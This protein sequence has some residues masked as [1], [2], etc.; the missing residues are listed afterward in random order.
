MLQAKA[1]MSTIGKVQRKGQ[2]TIPTEVRRQAGL[3]QGDI[4][5]FAFRRGKIVITPKPPIDASRF[6]TADDEY[7]PEQRRLIDGEIAKGLK[8]PYYGPFQNGAEFGAF[9][10]KWKANSKHV[11]L[12]K[13][14]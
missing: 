1:V 4:V 10:K 9:L 6:R 12:K 8:G 3:A 13:T 7:T 11:K 5:E 14:G 2:V